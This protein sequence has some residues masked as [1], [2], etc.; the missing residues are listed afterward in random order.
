MA[1]CVGDASEIRSLGHLPGE[2]PTQAKGGLEWATC[3]TPGYFCPVLTADGKLDC[4][5]K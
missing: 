1:V 4:S 3:R 5:P 2:I